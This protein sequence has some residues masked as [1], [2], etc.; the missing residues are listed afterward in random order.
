MTA[1]KA[2]T[3]DSG[4][5][6]DPVHTLLYIFDSRGFTASK[7][8]FLRRVKGPSFLL[9]CPWQNPSWNHTG[10]SSVVD[11]A[12]FASQHSFPLR[13]SPLSPQVAGLLIWKMLRSLRD[14]GWMQSFA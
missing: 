8:A 6:R 2:V 12:A 11:S 4:E 1:G 9:L 7:N 5:S 10:R 3:C 14:F 13:E